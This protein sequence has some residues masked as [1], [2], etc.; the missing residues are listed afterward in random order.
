MSEK[1]IVE[2]DASSVASSSSSSSSS[3]LSKDNDAISDGDEPNNFSH[4]MKL[5]RDGIKHREKILRRILL[6][7]EGTTFAKMLSESE[8]LVNAHLLESLRNHLQ[9]PSRESKSSVISSR[10][11]ASTQGF[12]R[13]VKN[14]VIREFRF[15]LPGYI[16]LITHCSLYLSIYG[17]L[18]KLTDSICDY[19]IIN[20]TGW[21]IK[22]NAFDCTQHERFFYVICLVM[23]CVM[24]R[25]T[26][27]IYAWNENE[28]FQQQLK[29]AM[30]SRSKSWDVKVVNWFSGKGNH[31]S[32]WRPRL[33]SMLDTFG[34]F[35]MY[36][37]ID[38][39]LLH[40]FARNVLDSRAI[41]LDGMPSRQLK[42]VGS[43]IPSLG[44]EHEAIGQCVSFYIDNDSSKEECLNSFAIPDDFT[45]DVINWLENKNRCGWIEKEG[46]YDEEDATSKVRAW[47]QHNEEW[48]Q[49]INEQDE[50]YLISNV[51]DRTWY[52][53]VGDPSAQF[54]DPQ[55]ENIFLVTLTL[56]G[57]AVLFCMGSPFILI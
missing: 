45:S 20:F 46:Q 36:I 54:I 21:H 13:A 43:S 8:D 28:S 9:S 22:E 44:D 12:L 57:F 11:Q 49:S 14:F 30:R 53:L 56:G 29:A 38:R 52:E 51:S 48:K 17:C 33:K 40:D 5:L 23:G 3:L 31:S 50:L 41:V 42:R 34:F 7:K 25:M 35:L 2:D 32:K 37:S 10:T 15:T 16:S 24:A 18:S 4:E 19:I 1:K 55:R 39:L 26:G 6:G 27:S 47:R